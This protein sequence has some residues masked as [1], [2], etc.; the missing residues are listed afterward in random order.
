MKDDTP[1]LVT[2]KPCHAPISM[3]AAM[4]PARRSAARHQTAGQHAST[5]PTSA[6]ADPTERSKLRVTISMHR[7]DR[8]E[9][10]DRGL[11]R[12]QHQIAR[13]QENAVG[14]EVEEQP[15]R[16]QDA[17]SACSRAGPTAARAWPVPRWR[18]VRRLAGDANPGQTSVAI[19][20]KVSS[21]R[22]ARDNSP[23]IAPR[24][25]TSTRSQTSTSSS[26][27]VE[28]MRMAR[29]SARSSAQTRLISARAPTSTPR[30]GID[31]D[32]DPRI[33]GEPARHLHFLLI[34]A[35]QRADQGLDRRRLDVEPA[36]E[37]RVPGAGRRRHR[38]SRDG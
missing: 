6:T 17:R 12:Q 37:I 35:G 11:Q 38:E 8:G 36:H 5:T 13:R 15:D 29:P 14:R 21:D 19:L 10:D 27:S 31:Q 24:R 25:N 26:A 32:Q 33:G 4:R 23:A 7:A 18:R 28:A 3:P 22:S 9:A 1:I 16:R 2:Q 34:A 20:N 30:V